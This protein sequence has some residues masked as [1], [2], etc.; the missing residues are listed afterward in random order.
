MKRMV[1]GIFLAIALG[2]LCV[3]CSTTPTSSTWNQTEIASETVAGYMEYDLTPLYKTRQTVIPFGAYN[4]TVAGFSTRFDE[5]K[6]MDCLDD[7]F[8]YSVS[9]GVVIQKLPVSGCY[10]GCRIAESDNSLDLLIYS[11]DD[12]GK[13]WLLWYRWELTENTLRLVMKKACDNIEDWTLLNTEEN[14]QLVFWNHENHFLTAISPQGDERV[15]LDLKGEELF[16]LSIQGRGQYILL[17]EKSGERARFCVYR[18][19]KRFRERELEKNEYIYS[20]HLLERGVILNLQYQTED[21]KNR[22]RVVWWPF[23]GQE[24]QHETNALYRG[25]TNG[26]NC[27]AFMEFS[28][29]GGDTTSLHQIVVEEKV[30]NLTQIPLN[31]KFS[32]LPQMLLVDR[33]KNACV[34]LTEDSR[35]MCVVPF[36]N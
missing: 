26:V 5:N 33:E 14:I 4:E 36:V 19:G 28:G 20:M 12:A 31:V 22:Y 11:C 16:D 2:I 6:E 34:I 7:L 1:I 13:K 32:T 30:C 24:T 27:V 35:C 18:K 10:L 25:V 17:L 23:D 9:E 8:L 21:S 29:W 3:S 15:L